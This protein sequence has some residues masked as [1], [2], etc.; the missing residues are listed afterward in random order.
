MTINPRLAAF[1]LALSA[2][3]VPSYASTV[4]YSAGTGDNAG[5]GGILFA[6]GGATTVWDSSRPGVWTTATTTPASDWVYLDGISSTFEYNFDLTG[7]DLSSVSVEIEWSVDNSGTIDLNTTN[8]RGPY[9]DYT[10]LDTFTIT[11]PAGFNAGSNTLSFFATG[12]GR[13]DGFRAAIE[14][15]GDLISAVPVP[16]TLPLLLGAVAIAAGRRKK[17][18]AQKDA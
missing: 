15:S 18:T 3:A 13:T 7:Y 16:A 9:T 14:V 12:D 11:G 6:G 10:S 8:V 1:A 5:P 4:I 17:R 2:L